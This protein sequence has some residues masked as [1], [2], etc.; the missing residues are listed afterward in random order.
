VILLKKQKK[1]NGQIANVPNPPVPNRAH[2]EMKAENSNGDKKAI[3]KVFVGLL[4]AVPVL[5]VVV[6]LLISSDQ[7]FYGLMTSIFSNTFSTVLKAGIGFVLSLFVIAYGFSLKF[8]RFAV[9]Q[10]SVF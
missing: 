10:N 7:A 3:G 6:P 4:C 5:I 9:K 1:P 8:G 2:T